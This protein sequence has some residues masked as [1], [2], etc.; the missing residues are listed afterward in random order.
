MLG[1]VVIV[2]IVIVVI[3]IVIVVIVPLCK[4]KGG[5]AHHEC[6]ECAHTCELFQ[7]ISEQHQHSPCTTFCGNGFSVLV[8]YR[9]DRSPNRFPNTASPKNNCNRGGYQQFG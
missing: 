4:A 1:V 5:K 8:E 6:Y 3:V 9:I 2:V 7:R